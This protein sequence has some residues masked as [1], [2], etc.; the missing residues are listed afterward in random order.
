MNMD[1][2]LHT[3]TGQADGISKGIFVVVSCIY[4]MGVGCIANRLALP[5]LSLMLVP[6][7][8]LAFKFNTFRFLIY[9]SG[10]NLFFAETFLVGSNFYFLRTADACLIVFLTLYFIQRP[11]FSIT[12]PRSGVLAVFYLYIAYVFIMAINPLVSKGGDYWLFYDLKKYIVLATTVFFCSQPIFGPKK[13]VVIL[14][15]FIFFTDLYGLSTLGRFLLSHER[16]I[17]WNEIYFS[18]MFIVSIVLIPL[19]RHRTLKISLSVGAFIL[20]CS[21]LATQTRSVWLSSAVC[22]FIY[23]MFFFRKAV[24]GI[25]GKKFL[26]VVLLL[27]I[28]VLFVEIVMNLAFNTDL[29][30]FIIGRMSKFQNN[31]LISPFSSLGYRMYESYSVWTNRTFW[32]HG[33]GAYL[34]LIQTQFPDKKFMYWWSIHSEYI[35]ILHKWGFVGLALYF[36][37]LGAFL[38]KSFQLFFSGKKFIS[39]VGAVAF[40][41][42]LNTAVISITSGYMMRVNM[43]MWD[44]VIIGIVVYYGNRGRRPA[45]KRRSLW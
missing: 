14:L 42:M 20:G 28:A 40:F 6:L 41:T 29:A 12:F 11:A 27:G 8:L 15:A 26:R 25:D 4:I 21:I 32:G 16:Q 5:V 35:E 19:L 30:A 3:F 44:I 24:H 38:F 2:S 17:T 9:Y 39:S 13:I 43:L 45:P 23:L 31:E 37:F 33:T 36:L 1:A 10:V 22:T 7:P 18:N 34:Y